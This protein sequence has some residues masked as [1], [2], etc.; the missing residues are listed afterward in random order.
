MADQKYENLSPGIKSISQPQPQIAQL[1]LQFAGPLTDSERVETFEDL[2]L[3]NP[4]YFY[5]QKLVWVKQSKTFYYLDNGDGTLLENWKKQN[6][7]L[8][9]DKYNPD[10]EYQKDECIYC[11]KKLY[12]ATQDVPAG[13]GPDYYEMYWECICGDTETYRYV[14]TNAS[15][16]IVYTDIRNPLFEIIT[17]DLVLNEDG[18]PTIDLE[19]GLVIINNQEIQEAFVKKRQ[20]LPNNDGSPYEISFEENMLPI[21]MS[22]VINI[23]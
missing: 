5:Q 1:Q 8:V 23:K 10:S 18:Y 21:K 9:V 17:G 19:T 2:L 20:D 15:N 16:V 11:N 12:K 14:F 4:K 22:G 7:K 6:A 13:F 3:L